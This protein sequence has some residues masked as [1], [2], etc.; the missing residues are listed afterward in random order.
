[1]KSTCIVHCIVQEAFQESSLQLLVL[2]EMCNKETKHYLPKDGFLPLVKD[3]HY[4]SIPAANKD[5][6]E[7][8]F[9]N[10]DNGFNYDSLNK[11]HHD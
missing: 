8:M 7:F 10:F 11:A 5:V 1:M 2:L 3:I 9:P 6:T 4:I